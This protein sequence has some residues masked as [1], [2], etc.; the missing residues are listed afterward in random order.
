MNRISRR[1]LLASAALATSAHAAAQT[2]STNAASRKLKVIIGGGHPGDP[3]YGCGGTIARYTALG[4]DVA[5]M[6]LN[7]GAWGDVKEEI[8]VAEAKKACVILKARPLF[9]G[10]RNGHAIVDPEHTA[11]FLKLLEAERA[12]VLIT[13]WPMDNHADHRA[14]FALVY[15]GWIRMGRK[16]ALYFY[17]VS[18]GEDTQMFSP[19]DFVDISAVESTKRAA[20]YAH[21]SQTPDRYYA[22]QTDVSRFRG[23]ECGARL[24]E[25]FVRHAQSRGGLL[26]SDLEGRS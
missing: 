3:E 2:A 13:Q 20:C 16:A 10:Q 22:L 4:H 15:D 5:L 18:D 14:I 1:S 21:A 17:E 24:A 19:S 23:F 25:G 12:D 6:Y 8:R 11:D 9:A 7:R 26:P